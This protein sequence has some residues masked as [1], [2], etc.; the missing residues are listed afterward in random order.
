MSLCE[1]I[2]VDHRMS[3]ICS[4]DNDWHHRLAGWSLSVASLCRT[5]E[6]RLTHPCRRWGSTVGNCAVRLLSKYFGRMV[7]TG[8]MFSEGVI[9]TADFTFFPNQIYFFVRELIFQPMIGHI[10]SF[11]L[12]WFN[13]LGENALW[14]EIV[15]DKRTTVLR[16]WVDISRNE[17]WARSGYDTVDD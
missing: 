6:R 5:R 13:E 11:G 2:S 15:S 17:S 3:V 12:A 1:A 10:P 4:S 9:G 8:E 14:G 16:L 7:R